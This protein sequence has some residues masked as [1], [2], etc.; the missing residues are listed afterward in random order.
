MIDDCNGCGVCCLHM[1]YP[2]YMLPR[3]PFTAEQI[4]SDPKC[5]EMLKRGW[6]REEL[7]EGFEGESFWQN[8]PDDLRTEWI[9]FVDKYEAPNE[10]DSACFWFDMETRQCKNHEYR[11]R[12]CRDFEIGSSECKECRQHYK[13]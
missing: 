11:P 10:L 5:R 2:A 13:I 7:L 4:E 3:E 1:G 8:M 12:V 6:T 9:E